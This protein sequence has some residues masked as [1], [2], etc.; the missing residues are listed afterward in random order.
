MAP[1]PRFL[2]SPELARVR[3]GASDEARREQPTLLPC[4]ACGGSGSILLEAPD[5][6]SYRMR[7]CRWCEGLG[8][9]GAKVASKFQRWT[10]LLRWA[11]LTGRCPKA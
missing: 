9:V 2:S 10:R 8:C 11:K 5:G 6:A 4:P 3:L 1:K 7:A